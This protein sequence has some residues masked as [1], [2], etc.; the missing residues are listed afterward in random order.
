MIKSINDLTDLELRIV[1]LIAN[2]YSMQ[3]ASKFLNVSYYQIKKNVDAIKEK[4]ES[5]TMISAVSAM[6]KNNII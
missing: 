4:C 6:S 3:E 2:G 5:N 1:I